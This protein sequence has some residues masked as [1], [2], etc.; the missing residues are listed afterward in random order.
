VTFIPPM[1]CSRLPSPSV[2]TERCGIGLFGGSASE[3]GTLCHENGAHGGGVPVT[4][5]KAK[6]RTANT[7]SDPAQASVTEIVTHVPQHDA[8]GR[9]MALLRPCAVDIATS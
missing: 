8:I 7:G 6:G 4:V 9:N 3:S 2:L 1:L 5:T